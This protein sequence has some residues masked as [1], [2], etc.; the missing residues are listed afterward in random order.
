MKDALLTVLSTV[1][2]VVV[3]GIGLFMTIFFFQQE[4]TFFFFIIG[5]VGYFISLRPAMDEWESRFK[6]WF[7]IKE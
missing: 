5:L 4:F 6:R 2:S 3:V 1:F 7:K